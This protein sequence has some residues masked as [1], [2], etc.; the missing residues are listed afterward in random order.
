VLVLATLFGAYWFLLRGGGGTSSAYLRSEERI[1]AAAR[2][3]PESAAQV[4][5]F[6]ELDTFAKAI[7]EQLV[8]IKAETAKLRTLAA[9][10]EGAEATIASTSADAATRITTSS[11]SYR[12]AIAGSNDL[13]DA[14]AALLD[15][16]ASIVKLEQQARAWK[17]L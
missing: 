14:D 15:I 10:S 4:Q 16:K 2:A 17:K 11:V 13:A 8:V 5:R 12:D 7:D 6:L 1:T 9:Q 3:V